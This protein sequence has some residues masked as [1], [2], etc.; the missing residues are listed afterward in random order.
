MDSHTRFEIARQVVDGLGAQEGI[1]IDENQYMGG[2][3]GSSL[4]VDYELLKATVWIEDRAVVI[5]GR[6][7][8]LAAKDE[9][10]NIVNI[11]V[12]RF[13]R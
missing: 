8:A 2:D 4:N 3:C 5:D 1:S 10:C 12:K 9:S 6:V 13:P 11:A 7:A